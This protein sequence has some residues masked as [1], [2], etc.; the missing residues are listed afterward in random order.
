MPEA[1]NNSTFQKVCRVSAVIFDMD[2]LMLDTEKL[3]CDI[4]RNVADRYGWTISDELCQALVGRNQKDSRGILQEAL[5]PAFPLE[6]I[7]NEFLREYERHLQEN[8]AP[9]KPGLLE[10]LDLLEAKHI[11][12][13]V[14]TSTSRKRAHLKLGV[15]GL[16]GRFPVVICGDEVSRGKPAPDIYLA[17][18]EQLAVPAAECL[19]LE[20]SDPGIQGA[21]AAG[22][23]PVMVP[24]L[25]PPSAESAN[26]AIC[27]CPSLLEAASIITKLLAAQ[28]TP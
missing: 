8:G 13:A 10:L 11:P 5:G 9:L 1:V 6:R 18:A 2:G 7:Q 26:L 25:K 14:A 17:A 22:M 27:L 15:C 19:V 23:I 21:A 3:A 12:K 28:E 4:H 20:D 24:D 16:S